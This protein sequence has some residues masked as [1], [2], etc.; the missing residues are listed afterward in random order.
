[1]HHA[2]V[3]PALSLGALSVQGGRD[4]GALPV[5]SLGSVKPQQSLGQSPQNGLWPGEQNSFTSE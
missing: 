3:N 4:W 2:E 1:M 5:V